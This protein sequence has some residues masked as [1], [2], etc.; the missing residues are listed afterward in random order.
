MLCKEQVASCQICVQG[1]E[2]LMMCSNTSL[3]SGLFEFVVCFVKV[4]SGIF[5]PHK[6]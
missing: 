3:E 4:H 2:I 1:I 5:V 6:P